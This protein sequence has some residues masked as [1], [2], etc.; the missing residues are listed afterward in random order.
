MGGDRAL[1]EKLQEVLHQTDDVTRKT[2][3]LEEQL[4]LSTVGREI[5]WSDKLQRY[6][7]G[8]E[9]LVLGDSIIQNVGIELSN[10]K[11]ECFP[12]IITEHLQIVIV[13]R[14]FRDP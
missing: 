11:F 12:S 9:C 14:D 7:E 6:P 4:R 3:T 5:S 13:N 10:M 8:R 1:E 2:K